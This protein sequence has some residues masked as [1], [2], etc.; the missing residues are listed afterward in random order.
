MPGPVIFDLDGTLVDSI[1]DIAAAMN[2]VLARAGMPTHDLAAYAAFVGEGAAMLVRRAAPEGADVDAL[3]A[4]FVEHYAA[5]CMDATRPYPGIGALVGE[6]RARGRR[7]GVLS[8]KPDA[9]T[10]EIVAACFPAGTF[11]AIAGDLPGVPRKPDPTSALALAERLG[12]APADCWLVGDTAIDIRTA[13]AAGMRSIAVGWGL[14]PVAELA[15]AA[16]DRLALDVNELAAL[17]LVP[18]R[19][20]TR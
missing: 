12:A 11:T 3:L 18:A 6:L 4:A 2:H 16:P 13:S 10:Q 15:L 1:S 5:H 7:L 19:T 17:L 9:L 8:N 14:R 20:S